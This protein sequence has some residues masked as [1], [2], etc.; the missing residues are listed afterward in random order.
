MYCFDLC[1]H[2][3]V[4]GKRLVLNCPLFGSSTNIGCKILGGG[5]PI[6]IL[7][8]AAAPPPPPPPRLLRPCLAMKWAAKKCFL[9]SS[10][11]QNELSSLSSLHLLHTCTFVMHAYVCVRMY[12]HMQARNY[13]CEGRPVVCTYLDGDNGGHSYMCLILMVPFQNTSRYVP[14]ICSYRP[15]ENAIYTSTKVQTL[16][17][18]HCI[19][20]WSCCELQIVWGPDTD[21]E[22]WLQ[23]GSVN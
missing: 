5:P 8:G 19:N 1:S 22:M 21:K 16:S 18:A 14:L 3:S 4:L 23:L 2:I 20:I 17:A 12:V 7:G 15:R 10:M 13:E 9:F 11:S 6:W